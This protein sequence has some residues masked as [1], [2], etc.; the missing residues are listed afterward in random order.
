MARPKPWKRLHAMCL[1]RPAAS[2][3][4]A[5]LDELASTGESGA[6]LMNPLLDTVVNESEVEEALQCDAADA[7]DAVHAEDALDEADADRVEEPKE[8]PSSSPHHGST[9]RRS[10]RR[11]APRTR[12]SPP[13]ANDDV[14][15]RCFGT[16]P[17]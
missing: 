10:K 6:V 13:V 17:Y 3:P 8:A 11:K 16:D 5:P 1:A 15:V 4:R 14:A 9:D 2:P 12:P 7:A